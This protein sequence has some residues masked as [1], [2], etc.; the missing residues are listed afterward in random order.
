[1]QKSLQGIYPKYRKQALS[2]IIAATVF[3]VAS[4][5]M[6]SPAVFEARKLLGHDVLQGHYSN[7]Q[8]N[9][10][11]E[12]SGEV[13]LW[14]DYMFSGMPHV[15]FSQVFRDVDLLSKLL[16]LTIPLPPSTSLLFVGFICFYILLL[17]F[18]VR[19]SISI[20][21][22]LMFG[23]NGFYVVGLAAGHFA[24]IRA[25]IFIPLVLSG[26]KLLFDQKR[27]WGFL[28]I[29]VAMTLHLKNNHLQM[30][31]YLLFIL[32]FF[33]LSQI[34]GFLIQG[35]VRSLVLIM[36]IALGGGLVG[37]L[38]NAGKLWWTYEYSKESTRG[39][40]VLDASQGSGVG[41][42]YAFRYSYGLFEP[43]VLFI[44]NILGGASLDSLDGDS[45]LAKELR[46]EGIPESDRRD[47]L[48]YAPVY[49]GDQPLTTPYY[50]GA[51]SLLFALLGFLFLGRRERWWLT[52]LLVL[53]IVW[54]WGNSF[55]AVNEIF[56][57]YLPGYNKFRSVTFSIVI[58]MICIGM[59]GALGLERLV[60]K[61]RDPESWKKLVRSL[62][63]ALGS[64]V[65]ILLYG[66]LFLK[67][68]GFEDPEWL[69]EA[70]Q[71]DRRDL[72]AKDILMTIL[73]IALAGVALVAWFW[74]AIKLTSLFIFLSALVLFDMV[75]VQKRYLKS[76]DFKSPSY[77]LRLTP[78]ESDE[79]ILQDPDPHY[80]VYRIQNPFSD[81]RASYFHKSIGGYH[82][83]KLRRYQDLIEE[84]I[85]GETNRWIESLKDGVL[86][87]DSTPILNML[88]TRYLQIARDVDGY[89]PNLQNNGP[90]WMI[91]RLV[92]AS[93]PRQEMDILKLMMDTKTMA[94]IDTSLF[95]INKSDFYRGS[96]RLEKHTPNRIV[97]EVDAPQEAFLVC[98]EIFYPHGWEA[99]IDGIP[100]Q[101]HRVNYT[102]R[103]LVIPAGSSQ[104]VFTFRPM[105]YVAGAKITAVGN[106]LILVFIILVGGR[107]VARR[108]PQGEG[109]GGTEASAEK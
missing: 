98:S 101:I 107:W 92:P 17:T 74:G 28:L 40:H 55:S 85:A 61:G 80:R 45:Q 60:S 76:D 94:V 7:F 2:H 108:M 43:L 32:L 91:E 72:Y 24:K 67:F 103:G 51:A 34:R 66:V 53:S 84:G 25:A 3:L 14:N 57:D 6:T 104:V 73:I 21:V 64:L 19:P 44:P 56:F 1:M 86:S 15:V 10:H 69:S 13:A 95:Q 48:E 59:I 96:V 63:I 102:L 87:F 37:T 42:E 81:A 20:I 12:K 26:M 30:T 46:K 11:Q 83:A 33:T 100:S 18:K 79:E 62:L 93:S 58:T 16:F 36:L 109:A 89:I 90:A 35:R 68:S 52:G 38:A 82:P 29:C 78:W 9:L 106:L 31:Y 8:P 39:M 88:N 22:S 23:L 65:A 70:L 54:S 5:I 41:K 50:A 47:I 99:K 75:R 49:W 71:S 77:F 27:L 105:P 4:V 97:Y